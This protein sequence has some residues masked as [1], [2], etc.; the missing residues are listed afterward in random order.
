MNIVIKNDILNIII[1]TFVN[2]EFLRL[3]IKAQIA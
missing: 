1:F 3:K 2:V